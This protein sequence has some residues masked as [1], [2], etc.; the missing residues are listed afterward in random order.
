VREW[1]MVRMR[2]SDLLEENAKIERWVDELG[3]AGAA[4]GALLAALACTQWDIGC[5]H[6]AAAMLALH[7]ELPERGVVILEGAS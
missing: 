5:A 4:N 2:S 3:D 7:G 1:T 6:A